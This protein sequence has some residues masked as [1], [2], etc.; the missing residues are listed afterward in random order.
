M[1]LINRKSFPLH[2]GFIYS[3]MLISLSILSSAKLPQ[4]HTVYINRQKINDQTINYLEQRYRIKIEDG[5]Y[6]YD[7]QTG[8]WG[9]EG[10]PTRGIGAAGLKLGGTLASNASAGNT[11]VF[12]NRRELPQADLDALENLLGP[13]QKGYY[14]MD[15]Q[16]NAGPVGGAAI[17]NVWAV[18]KQSQRNSSSWIYRN[19]YTG[20]GG[21]SDGETTYF[22][23]KDFYYIK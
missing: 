5:R 2:L 14:W 17:V 3:L 21:G 4:E 20:I 22:I 6:W 11:K 18:A 9:Y 8:L 13:I 15:A 23:G 19:N 10:G 7:S 12:I 1:I 16:G